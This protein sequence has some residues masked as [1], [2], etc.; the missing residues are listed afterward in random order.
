M[1][2]T[3]IAAGL[4]GGG[5]ERVVSELATEFSSAGNDVSVIIIGSKERSYYIPDDVHVYDCADRYPVPGISFIRRIG[6]IRKAIKKS[7][8]DVCISFNT[9]VNIYAILSCIGLRCKLVISERN[10]PVCYPKSKPE[11]IMRSLLYPLAD[12]FVFQTRE[13]QQ[14][15]SEKIQKRSRVIFN[16]INRL[17][18]EAFEGE[19]TSRIVTACRL[20]PQKNL[21]MAIDAFEG[22]TVNH[23]E[24]TFEIYGKGSLH[25]LL[26]DYIT[27]KGLQNRVFLMGNST[28]LYEDIHNAY[29][30]VLSSDF[31]GMSNSMLEAIALG[32]PTVSTDYP[33]GGARAVIQDGING[34]LVPVG[35]TEAMSRALLSLIESPGKAERLKNNGKKL[36]D[37]LAIGRIAEE[38]MSFI[39]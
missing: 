37:D 35:D 5:A 36:R 20:E 25:S 24:F 2:I 14:F 1:R 33:S 13:A 32:I 6:E 9:N 8:P 29:A 19:R 3:F 23:P 22:A 12:K 21:K 38:W 11:R 7:K 31:E 10:D 4:A 27:E 16:P 15:F 30:F 39:K 34:I 18:P 28:R 17:L 26:A